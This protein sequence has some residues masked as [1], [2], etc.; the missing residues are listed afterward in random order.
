VVLIGGSVDPAQERT[1]VIQRLADW[2]LVSWL[3]PC[4]LRQC[5]RELLTLRGDLVRLEPQ[6]FALTVPVAMLQGGKDHQVPAAN[7]DY[8]R[9]ELAAAGKTNL[10]DQLV[11]PDYNHFIPWE[12]PEAVEAAIRT[13]TDRLSHTAQ[14]Q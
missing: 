3:V 8:M 10:F 2:P 7:V 4:A 6:L 14:N 11:F 1:Y 9:A 5:N 13:V 12:H